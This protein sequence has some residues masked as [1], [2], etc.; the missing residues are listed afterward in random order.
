[1]KKLIISFTVI[2]L[3]GCG[4]FWPKT[5][6]YKPNTT[7]EVASQDSRE[8]MYEANKAYGNA[9]SLYYQCME[10][11]GYEQLERL[12]GKATFNLEQAQKLLPEGTR[13]QRADDM[14]LI[15]V[16]GK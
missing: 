1:M 11:R 2:L 15:F 14:G 4:N 10:V 13:I 8:C 16:S 9:I 12:I 6:W 3:T 7:L 5:I